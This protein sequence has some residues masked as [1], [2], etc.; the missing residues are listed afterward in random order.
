M[1]CLFFQEY[2]LSSGDLFVSSGSD[3]LHNS[4]YDCL[5][6]LGDTV[7][8]YQSYWLTQTQGEGSL[9]ESEDREIGWL[10]LATAHRS[11][12]LPPSGTTTLSGEVVK[13][14]TAG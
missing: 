11:C 12:T 9:Q 13:V 8:H 2:L 14:T 3:E 4:T 10:W 7:V 5:V 6:H 1:I